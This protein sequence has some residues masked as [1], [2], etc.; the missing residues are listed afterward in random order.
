M[1][2][3]KVI[4]EEGKIADEFIEFPLAQRGMLTIDSKNIIFEPIK[5]NAGN[6]ET[7]TYSIDNVRNIEKGPL[8]LLYIMLNDDRVIRLNT[9]S[10]SKIIEILDNNR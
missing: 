2:K 3:F 1:E 5:L 4:F 9:T 10:K 7:R 6:I 8:T